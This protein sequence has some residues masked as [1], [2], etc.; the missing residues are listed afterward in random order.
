MTIFDKFKQGDLVYGLIK[1]RDAVTEKLTKQG[2]TYT[3]ANKLNDPAVSLVMKGSSRRE[4]E[5]TL[6]YTQTKHFRFLRRHADYLK[7]LPGRTIPLMHD[8]PRCGAAYRRAC[9]LL[10]INR[11]PDRKYKTHVMTKDIDWRRVCD[12]T[13]S[14]L[15]V[16]D[17]EMRAAF[18]DE[19]RHGRNPN[20]LFYDAELNL[21]SAPPW[22]K[23][24]L[25]GIFQ[26]Y[27]DHILKKD[28]AAK[29][30]DG[31]VKR[32]RRDVPEEDPT[33]RI[34]P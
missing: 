2:F 19:I 11:D 8:D 30:E 26:S 17:S 16:T 10:L 12:K 1:P 5:K 24:E 31:S 14:G 13:K 32:K 18:R 33:R 29:K 3:Y 7:R 9:K 34:F 20:I 4:A 6:D 23:P 25:A 15:G 27:R 21:L 22:E 28:Q